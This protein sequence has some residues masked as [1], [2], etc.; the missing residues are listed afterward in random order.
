M[1]VNDRYYW[2]DAEGASDADCSSSNGSDDAYFGENAGN[3][4][5]G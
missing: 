2:L 4:G 5:G 3:G 1:D